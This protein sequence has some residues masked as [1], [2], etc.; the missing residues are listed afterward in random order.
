MFPKC[1][2]A[3][4]E[5]GG[6]GGGVIEDTACL[7]NITSKNLLALKFELT[8]KYS[9]SKSQHQLDKQEK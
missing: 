1:A 2:R 3:D 7:M 6:G 4:H 9:A 8:Q 5:L